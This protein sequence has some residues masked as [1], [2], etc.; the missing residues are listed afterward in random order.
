MSKTRSVATYDDLKDKVVVI[1]GGANGIGEALV[2]RFADQAA[3]VHFCDLDADAGLAL[4]ASTQNRT[5][6]T[7][8]DLTREEEVRRWIDQVASR[9]KRIDVL[10]NNAARDP[11]IDLE[12][13]TMREWDSI[14][15]LNLRAY[16]IAI[17][18]SV[19]YITSGE[20]SIINFSS[21]THHLSPARMSA[22]VA[23]KSG[24][25]GLSRSLARELG[26]KGI[27]VNTLSPGWIMTKRQLKQFVTD[28]VRKML[29]EQQCISRLIEPA[30]IAEVALFLASQASTAI[31]GQELLADRGWAHH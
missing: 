6:F 4:Q 30:E 28:D 22:Y 8:V 15:A 14:F 2:R 9:D 16:V 21:I 24:I 31:T 20:G 1:T 29:S 18:Q 7:P 27:R 3:R 13:I 5:S 23:T 11:R 10:I 19:R 17:Q 26:P 25:I 12:D